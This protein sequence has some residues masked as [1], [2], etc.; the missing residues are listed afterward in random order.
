MLSSQEGRQEGEEEEYEAGWTSGP[1]PAYARLE[2]TAP[3]ELERRGRGRRRRPSSSSTQLKT[4]RRRARERGG[5]GA[6]VC[7]GS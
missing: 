3:T 6:L 1:G 7:V 5:S 4:G 2:D